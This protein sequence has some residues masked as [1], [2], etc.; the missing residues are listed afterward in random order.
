M[1]KA[2]EERLANG[3]QKYAAFHNHHFIVKIKR[4]MLGKH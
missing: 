3:V 4:K 2:E 1:G